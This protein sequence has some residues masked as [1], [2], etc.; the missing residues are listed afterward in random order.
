MQTESYLRGGANSV[1]RQHYLE[2]GQP[3]QP[4]PQRP[5]VLIP[6]SQYPAGAQRC[7]EP[8][9]QVVGQGAMA[10]RNSVGGPWVPRLSPN[11]MPVV[12]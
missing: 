12:L 4:Q 2:C 3:L 5:V 9:A 6:Q 10:G 8:A 11:H 1:R 7:P